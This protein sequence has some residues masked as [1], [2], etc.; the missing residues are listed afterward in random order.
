MSIFFLCL[1]LLGAY[2]V[3]LPFWLSNLAA[4]GAL[5][6]IFAYTQEKT[7]SW[8]RRI[9]GYE[10]PFGLLLFAAWWSVC[11]AYLPR[12]A[13]GDALA[14]TVLIGIFYF[15]AAAVRSAKDFNYLLR[16]AFAGYI[17]VLVCGFLQYGMANWSW[18][19]PPMFFFLLDARG[20]NRICSVFLAR[21]GT[22][23][24]AA[25]LSL[26][27]PAYLA[28]FWQN[29]L[30]RQNPKHQLPAVLYQIFH[31]AILA[32]TV[33]NIIFSFSRALLVSLA[34][35]FI[36]SFARS[37]YW[38]QIFAAGIILTILAVLFVAPLQ[39]TVRSL[40]DPND[41]SNRDHSMLAEISLRQIARHPLNGWGGGHLNAKLKQENGR[42]TNLRGQYKTPEELRRNYENMQ[43][44]QS[45]A[46]ADGVVYVFSP[47]NMYLGYFLEYGFLSFIGV[48]LLIVFTW[49]RLRRLPGSL[50]YSLALGI[51]GF[52]VYGL[53]QDSVR[54]PIMAYLL[55]FYLLLVLKLE[56]SRRGFNSLQY[57]KVLILA[58]HRVLPEAKNALA[59]AQKNFVRQIAYLRRRKYLFMN[60]EDFYQKYI[61]QAAPLL[62]K[63]CLITFDDGYRDNLK[64][65]W[66]V[67][68]KYNIP[69]TIFVTVNKIGSPEPY[70]WDFKNQT[71]FSKD[72]LPLDWPELKHL[73]KSGWTIGSHTLNHYALKQLSDEEAERELRLSKQRLEKELSCPVNTVCY[74]R[75]AADDRVL[76]LARANGYGLGFVTN[77]RMDDL[78]AFPRVGV[79]AH[80]T[81]WRFRLKLLLH[82]TG[83]AEN[84]FAAARFGANLTNAKRDVK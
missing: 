44:V 33:F 2:L 61:A 38:K 5:G 7:W 55:W 35:V 70:Y 80:D 3:A 53:F 48:I 21:S 30:G 24:F 56:E 36:V 60:A 69:A 15:L 71:Q 59:V 54:A 34:V 16:A 76:G 67:L 62:N 47:H 50:A 84:I 52:A 19:R 65:A 73:Q 41:A 74:P 32:L 58:Y 68:Q 17:F 27:A 64:Y 13:L 31:I 82:R 72:D 57:R 51:L 26:A 9:T 25:F 78:L 49:R 14:L 75:G 10:L 81:F 77:S 12:Q 40:F 43:V 66:P 79:Y 42:W 46:L 45:E 8:T 4:A 39:K 63:I 28:W 37:K 18:P 23:V 22:N 1:T 29:I 11:D 83:Q 20:L 6:L